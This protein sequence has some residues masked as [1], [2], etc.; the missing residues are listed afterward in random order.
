MKWDVCFTPRKQTSVSYAAG[1]DVV[2]C[3]SS[4][5]DWRAYRVGPYYSIMERFLDPIGLG[6]GH[7]GC[8]IVIMIVIG[9]MFLGKYIISR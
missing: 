4:E 5:V 2:V 8:A 1:C 9:C 3:Y 7:V 6:L